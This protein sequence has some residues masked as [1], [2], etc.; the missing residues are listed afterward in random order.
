VQMKPSKVGSSASTSKPVKLN[1]YVNSTVGAADGGQ[2][3]PLNS[4]TVFYPKGVTA[5]PKDFAVCQFALLQNNQADQC[6]PKSII[7]RGTAAVMARP[8]L[9]DPVQADVVAYNTEAKGGKPTMGL[10]AKARGLPVS[11]PLQGTVVKTGKGTELRVPVPEIVPV[12][13]IPPAS[14][15]QFGVRWNVKGKKSNY[16]TATAACPKGG[17]KYG[18]QFNYSDGTSGKASEALGC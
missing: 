11:I 16:W 9:Q 7:G 3:T 4:G 6:P 17:W 1:L 15:V 10:F 8:A 12:P 5:N 13:G 14:I 18:L 2:P